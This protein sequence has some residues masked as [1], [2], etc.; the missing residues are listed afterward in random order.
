MEGGVFTS[1]DTDYWPIRAFLLFL[2]RGWLNITSTSLLPSTIAR[3]TTTSQSVE[4]NS[5]IPEGPRQWG[6]SGLWEMNK[7]LG[8]PWWLSGK[9]SACQC[10]RQGFDPWSGKISRATMQLSPCTQ[11]LSW[12]LEPAELQPL[13]PTWPRASGLQQENLERL[14]WRAYMQGGKADT[15]VKNRL[16][17]QWKRRGWDDLREQH[18]NIHITMCKAA[19]GSLMYDAGHPKRVLCDSLKGWA[20]EGGGRGVQDGGDTYWY[21]AKPS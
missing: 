1:W 12:A 8:P 5:A 2:G 10:R 16:W 17:T 19:S 7:S 13:K 14:F 20:G 9:K 18:W 11:P 6:R 15:D 3:T 4:S 21:T